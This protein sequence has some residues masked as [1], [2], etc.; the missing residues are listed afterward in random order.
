MT[1]DYIDSTFHIQTNGRGCL[2][3]FRTVAW[4]N[5]GNAPGSDIHTKEAIERGKLPECSTLELGP[6]DVSR[7]DLG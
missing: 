3:V 5:A 6:L 1:N 4:G 7:S 2:E